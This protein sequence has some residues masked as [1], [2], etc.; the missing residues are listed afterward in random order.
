[1]T[2][3]GRKNEQSR[4]E[5]KP[6]PTPKDPP[7]DKKMKPED[8]TIN[9]KEK[10]GI[11]HILGDANWF[12]V[13]V[14]II[15][16]FSSYL[17]YRATKNLAVTQTVAYVVPIDSDI[18]DPNETDATG[19]MKLYTRPLKAGDL[20]HLIVKFT[21]SGATP[22]LKVRN[23]YTA[24]T[25]VNFPP[26]NIQIGP[27]VGVQS[28]RVIAKDGPLSINTA[29]DT[30]PLSPKDIKDLN[31]PI[32]RDSFKLYLVIYGI[33]TYEDIFANERATRFCFYY[34]PVLDS[35]SSCPTHNYLTH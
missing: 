34:N 24:R 28:N 17:Q 16:G 10:Q 4:A 31:T 12:M 9:A 19:D 21:N 11:S 13:I 20:P 22:A 14:T 27:V 3:K 6:A 26:D 8:S 29:L 35:M 15:L 23:S 5:R 2:K 7:H 30:G 25:M 18:L 1:M 33:T 32:T